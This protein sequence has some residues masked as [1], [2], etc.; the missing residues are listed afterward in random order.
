[1]NFFVGEERRR[2]EWGPLRGFTYG[3]TLNFSWSVEKGKAVNKRRGE[4]PTKE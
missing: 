3:L 2:K 4:L 1:M